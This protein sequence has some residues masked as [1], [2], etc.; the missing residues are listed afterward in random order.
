MRGRV[1]VLGGII[2]TLSSDIAPANTRR[3][4]LHLRCKVT[5]LARPNAFAPPGRTTPRTQKSVGTSPQ[6]D[7]SAIRT[8][9]ATPSERACLQ[10]Q[11]RKTKCLPGSGDSCSYCTKAGKTCVFSEKQSRTPLTRRNLDA[12]EERL[13]Q[14]EAALQQAGSSVPPETSRPPEPVGDY[15][16]TVEAEVATA[17]RSSKPTEEAATPYEWNESLSGNGVH[18]A[19][20]ARKAP[21]GM[22]LFSEGGEAAGYLGESS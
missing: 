18:S 10:C 7:M 13:R 21:D 5:A 9:R 12:A 16:E 2:G 3:L 19:S 8:S 4:Q 11:R 6:L 1:A 14:L 15:K 17:D 22:A 20:R